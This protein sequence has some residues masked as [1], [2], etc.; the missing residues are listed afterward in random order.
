M[1]ANSFFAQKVNITKLNDSYEPP[2]NIIFD[3]HIEPMNIPPNYIKRRIEV[4][5]LRDTAINFG[6]KLSLQ[7]N[8]EYMEYFYRTQ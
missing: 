1:T 4:N 6:A 5:W 2:I 3:V 8:G 7:T